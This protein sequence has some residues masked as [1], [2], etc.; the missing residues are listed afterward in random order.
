MSAVCLWYLVSV[1][2]LMPD[3][4]GRGWTKIV[5][6]REGASRGVGVWSGHSAGYSLALCASPVTGALSHSHDYPNLLI[7]GLN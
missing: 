3:Y 1:R 6:V 7:I 5:R 2:L 4:G